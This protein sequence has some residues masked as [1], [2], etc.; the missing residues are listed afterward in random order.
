MKN[1]NSPFSARQVKQTRAKAR[2]ATV[3][4]PARKSQR[5]ITRDVLEQ[6]P[7]ICRGSRCDCRDRVILMLGWASGSGRRSEITGL[8]FEDV[9]PKEFDEKSLVWI[10]LLETKSET[11]RLVLKGRAD[12]VL[13]HWIEVGGIT[14]GP[15]FRPV[16]K[17]D[18]LPKR[19]LSPDAIYQ[20][21]KHRLRF[22]CLAGGLRLATWATLGLPDSG[23]TGRRPNPGRHAPLSASLHGPATEIL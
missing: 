7:A 15:L 16:S 11:P 5:P 19:R 23:R 12:Q 21:V 20:S 10:S 6:L 22:V 8:M 1:L 9:S 13:V 3:R 4:A 18:C 17:A 2:R 14:D